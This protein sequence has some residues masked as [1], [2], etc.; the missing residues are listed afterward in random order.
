MAIPRQDYH[1]I[2]LDIHCHRLCRGIFP[3]ALS[4]I[5]KFETLNSL[6]MVLIED[7]LQIGPV[8]GI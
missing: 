7:L 3:H 5:E 2:I 6:D 8:V 4:R 1:L